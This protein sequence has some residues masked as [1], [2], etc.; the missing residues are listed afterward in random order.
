VGIFGRGLFGA[1]D[2]LSNRFPI[3][4]TNERTQISRRFRHQLL[5]LQHSN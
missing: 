2:S 4:I 5:E 1:F 3:V